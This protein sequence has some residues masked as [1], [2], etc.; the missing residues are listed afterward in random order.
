MRWETTR[1]AADTDGAILEGTMWFA[2]RM[3]GPPVHVHP[4]AEETFTVLEGRIEVLLD[5]TWHPVDAGETSVVPK[6]APHSVRNPHDDP[7]KLV[8]THSP[9]GRM[10]GFFLDG[11]ALAGAGKITALPPKDATSAI[12]GAMLFAKYPEEIVVVGPPGLAFRALALAGRALR[13]RV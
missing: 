12:Y 13:W 1:S 10:E 7:A 11:A 5:G 4:D 2:P 6:G 8:N 3:A 9:A